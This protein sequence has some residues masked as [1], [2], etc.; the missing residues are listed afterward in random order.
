MR[1]A[2]FG[3]TGRTGRI[4]VE[5]ALARGD[6]VTMLARDPAKVDTQVAGLRV[7][8]GDV[9]D[10]Q[11][12]EGVIQG[13]EAVIS[14]MGPSSNQ[15]EYAVSK[16]IGNI[17]KSMRKMGV[18]RLILSTG[19]GV[20]APEDNP[21]LFD[22]LMKII[23]KATARYVYEDL[24]KSIDLVRQS[25]LEWTVV[26][27]PML[28][29]RPGTRHVK[30]GYLGKGMGARITREDLAGFILEQVRDTRYIRK[31]PVVCNE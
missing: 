5:R 12:V 27:A 24:Q 18:N 2:I 26:R 8:Q 15:P 22:R 20:G 1:L 16:G 23:L 21:G 10:A 13:T 11:C 30:A 25:D 14:V 28:T 31:S 3:G 9:R 19:A 7:I 17:L 29:N 6:E 4:L